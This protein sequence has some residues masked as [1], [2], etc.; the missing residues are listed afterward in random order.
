MELQKK[1]RILSLHFCP[2][3]SSLVDLHRLLSVLISTFHWT[4]VTLGTI[5]AN[6][7]FLGDTSASPTASY[8]LNIHILLSLFFSSPNIFLSIFPLS[9][10]TFHFSPAVHTQFSLLHFL[11]LC[12]SF[13]PLQTSWSTT[14]TSTTSLAVSI[15][16]QYPT[17]P[18]TALP[19]VRTA[20]GLRADSFTGRYP[21]KFTQ[22]LPESSSTIG[23]GLLLLFYSSLFLSFLIFFLLWKSS[24]KCVEISLSTWWTWNAQFIL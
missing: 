20:E 5:G 2:H 14:G 11:S 6:F 4:S 21:L 18:C 12:F 23:F 8:K 9:L 3:S 1:K 7:S 17:A 15:R 19:A 16:H 24:A 10:S 22:Y 13:L